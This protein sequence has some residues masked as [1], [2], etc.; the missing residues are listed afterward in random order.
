[1]KKLYT[2][3]FS[4]VIY[5]EEEAARYIINILTED[6]VMAYHLSSL[7]EITNKDQLPI[8]WTLDKYPIID[9]GINLSKDNLGSLFKQINKKT[10]VLEEINALKKRL[11]ELEN[12]LFN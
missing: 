3:K 4:T 9:G 11:T 2:A 5:A 10:T 8:E 6:G 12:Q 7:C 1:M